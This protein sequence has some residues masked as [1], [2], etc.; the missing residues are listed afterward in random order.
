MNE[1]K[2]TGC[3]TALEGGGGM[4]G[5]DEHFP[6]YSSKEYLPIMS[7]EGFY[8]NPKKIVVDILD[9]TPNPVLSWQVVFMALF[10]RTSLED[11]RSAHSEGATPSPAQ[12]VCS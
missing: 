11:C 6:K 12:S 2:Y 8:M 10:C 1:K 3:C 9:S 5:V 7:T 4:S